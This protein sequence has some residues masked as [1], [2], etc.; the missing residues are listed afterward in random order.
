MLEDSVLAMLLR[1]DTRLNSD[2]SVSATEIPDSLLPARRSTKV[3]DIRGL[4][5]E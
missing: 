2:A 1:F 5:G 4:E 3:P